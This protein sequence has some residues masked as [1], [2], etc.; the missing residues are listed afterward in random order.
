MD[1]TVSFSEARQN[2]TAISERVAREGVEVTV[3]KRSKPLFKIVPVEQQGTEGGWNRQEAA[4]RAAQR[5]QEPGV[6]TA[7]E[8][9][10]RAVRSHLSDIPDGGEELLAYALELRKRTALRGTLTDLTGDDVKR[11]WEERDV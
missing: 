6:P 7:H 8:E 9:R 1:V 2:L 11:E 10:M 4:R 3:F 5:G